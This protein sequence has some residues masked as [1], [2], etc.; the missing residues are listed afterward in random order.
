MPHIA[1]DPDGDKAIVG[2]ELKAVLE[3][4]KHPFVKKYKPIGETLCGRRWIDYAMD[5]RLIYCLRNG[6]PLDM[7]VY[8]AAEWS[9]LVELTEL[10]AANGGAP[11]EIPDFTR[12]NWNTLKGVH[13]AK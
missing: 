2:D 7:D 6:L 8:D 5:S 10:S 9:S 13:F 12:G 1:L 4:Y 11:I 3:Q